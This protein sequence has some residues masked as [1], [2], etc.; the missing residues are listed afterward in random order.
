MLLALQLSSFGLMACEVWE[1]FRPSLSHTQPVLRV[2][3]PAL[4]HDAATDR[5]VHARGGGGM[6]ACVLE[7]EHFSTHLQ[8]AGVFPLSGQMNN[9]PLKSQP[10]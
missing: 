9:Q 1:H 7:C 3:N 6:R 8:K 4:L 10:R 5:H 2:H